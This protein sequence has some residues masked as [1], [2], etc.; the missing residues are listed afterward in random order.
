MLDKST[1]NKKVIYFRFSTVVFAFTFN[2]IIL[3]DE[4][5]FNV[6]V[7]P[8]PE[9]TTQGQGAEERTLD[10]MGILSSVRFLPPASC[11]TRRKLHHL[12]GPHF[13]HRYKVERENL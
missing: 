8:Y 2:V 5:L 9:D 6:I 13:A 12:S 1:Y 3:L 11:V 10:Y 4:F 7:T